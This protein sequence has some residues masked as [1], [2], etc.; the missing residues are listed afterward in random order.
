MTSAERKKLLRK[1]KNAYINSVYGSATLGRQARD[2][3]WDRI[4]KE[5][6]LKKP[7]KEKLDKYDESKIREYAPT[8]LAK[9]QRELNKVRTMVDMGFKPDQ[10]YEQKKKTFKWIDKRTKTFELEGEKFKVAF[11]E[12]R[13]ERYD[14]WKFWSDKTE[15]NMPKN[16][17]MSARRI[18]RTYDTGSRRYPKLSETDHYGFSFMYFMFIEDKTPEQVKEMIDP[19]LEQEYKVIYKDV[20]YVGR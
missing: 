15:H 5:L 20:Q 12:S 2:W 19:D 8:T 7:P 3:G 6:A 4:Y 9:K 13:L 17:D 10:V 16:I 14:L 18:N 11:P 1:Q